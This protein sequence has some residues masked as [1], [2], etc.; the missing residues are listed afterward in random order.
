MRWNRAVALTSWGLVK[1]IDRQD[2]RQIMQN[3]II[4]DA[5]AKAIAALSL[6]VLKICADKIGHE[7]KSFQVRFNKAFEDYLINAYSHYAVTK[8]ILYRDVPVNLYEYYVHIDLLL[9]GKTI[10]TENAQGVY[11]VAR[12]IVIEGMAGCGKSTLTRHL[13]LDTIKNTSLVPLYFELRNLN[14]GDVS[15][16]DAL[17]ERISA[18]GFTLEREY[19]VAALKLGKFAVFLDGY[20]EINS[21]IR[22]QVSDSI[23]DFAERYRESVVVVSSRSDDT[24]VSWNTFSVF[25]TKPFDKNK[26][27]ELVAKF[28]Y[29][30]TIRN[31]FLGELRDGLFEKH[32]SFLSNPLL[33]TIMLMTYSQFADIPTKVHI[34]Y[35]QAFDTLFSRHDAHKGAYKR[36]MRSKLSIDDFRRL[37]ACFSVLSYF[38]KKIT[39]TQTELQGYLSG[40]KK[41]TQLEYSVDDV[42]YDLLNAVCILKE[43]GV[44]ISFTHRSFQEYFAAVFI[45]QSTYK[46]DLFKKIIR[47]SGRYLMDSVAAILFELDRDFVEGEFIIPTLKNISKLTVYNPETLDVC[48]QKYF[49]ARKMRMVLFPDGN[50]EFRFST[51]TVPIFFREFLALVYDGQ[52]SYLFSDDQKQVADFIG[53]CSNITNPQGKRGVAIEHTDD[54]LLIEYSKLD[55]ELKS[56]YLYFMHKMEEIDAKYA[57]R[58]ESVLQLLINTGKKH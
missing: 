33:L 31:K 8:T 24:F 12:R 44:E 10:N 7:T 40:T 54:T 41:I 27:C 52:R 57:G 47:D 20:D 35:S 19:F 1:S 32:R 18:L 2:E 22:K 30:N 15:I 4:T 26:A 17:Y 51:D 37:V 6:N 50:R 46:A 23:Q 55:T 29:D 28:N 53:R 14:K 9:A 42:V 43:D 21:G 11:D 16:I 48:V 49:K 36:E 39:L 56:E 45:S 3:P 38:D 34:F 13:F 58:H 5:C 25:K